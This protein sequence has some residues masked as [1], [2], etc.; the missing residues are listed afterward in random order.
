MS[1]DNA[2]LQ[3]VID[4]AKALQG[5]NDEKAASDAALAEA[6]TAVEEADALVDEYR[7]QYDELTGRTSPA[8]IRR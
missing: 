8:R 4:T 2:H 7:R 5:A 3:K 1:Y 6:Q